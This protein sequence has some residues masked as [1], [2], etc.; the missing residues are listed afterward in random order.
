MRFLVVALVAAVAACASGAPG[1]S[2]DLGPSPFPIERGSA[3]PPPAGH[4]AVHAPPEGRHAGGIDFG[5]WRSAE[6]VGY[7]ADFVA[8]IRQRYAGRA[9]ADIRADLEG[10][11]F[12]C[13]DAQRLDCRIEI[14]ERDCMYDWYVVLERGEREPIVGFD[15]A[16]RSGQGNG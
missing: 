14:A 16:C 8:Q 6:P 11:G 2:A 12:A 5:A 1:N 15:Q 9:S 7:A 3:L 10:N 13:E 4:S